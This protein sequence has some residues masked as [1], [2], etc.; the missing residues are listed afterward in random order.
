MMMM[1][2]N[3]LHFSSFLMMSLFLIG[4]QR[5]SLLCFYTKDANDPTRCPKAVNPVKEARE[6][7]AEA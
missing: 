2:K 4:S 7:N 1:N 3:T 6:K 5:T